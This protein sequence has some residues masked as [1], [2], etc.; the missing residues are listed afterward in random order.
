MGKELQFETAFPN[1]DLSGGKQSAGQNR[2]GRKDYRR[3]SA[4]PH[5]VRQDEICRAAHGG[6][7]S[8]AAAHHQLRKDPQHLC[9]L[10]KGWLLQEI[11]FGA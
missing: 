9:C 1:A 4:V 7:Q 5:P 6:N 11:P 10:P 2:S 3:H 8:V